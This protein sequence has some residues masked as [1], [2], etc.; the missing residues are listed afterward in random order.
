MTLPALAVERQVTNRDLALQSP[1]GMATIMGPPYWRNPRHLQLID[2]A[3]VRLE[4]RELMRLQVSSPP[5]HGKSEYCSVW[6]VFWY[7]VKNPTH[8]VI[9]A[10]YSSDFASL[11]GMRVRELV[12]T[13]GPLFGLKLDKHGKQ[14]AQWWQLESGGEMYCAGFGAGI[15]G[16]GADVL[17]I[18]DPI[19]NSEQAL[20]EPFRQK[21][22]DWYLSTVQTRLEPG[23]L[24]LIIQTRWHEHDISGRVEKMREPPW[25]RLRFPAIAGEYNPELRRWVAEAGGDLLGREHRQATQRV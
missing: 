22:W 21:Q 19:N 23:A 17:L 4:R 6:F 14:T 7:L 5:R 11:F 20:S 9:L 16:R 15:S 8:R 3:V 25:L 24:V 1:L 10:S 12:R 2:R 13:I 18:D